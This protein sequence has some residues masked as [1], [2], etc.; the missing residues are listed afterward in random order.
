VGSRV[1]DA[2]GGA[3]GSRVGPG[4]GFR[5]GD[6]VGAG[7]GFSVGA[8][9]GDGVGVLQIGVLSSLPEPDEGFQLP[10]PE[11]PS[12]HPPGRSLSLDEPFHS[13]VGSMI[14]TAS[15]HSASVVIFS[16]PL[17]QLFVPVVPNLK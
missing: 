4:V 13:P 8:T 10:L 5:V 16:S 1:G 17:A 15:S 3:V 12:Q 2:V 6:R 7:V 9:V 11:D 14:A